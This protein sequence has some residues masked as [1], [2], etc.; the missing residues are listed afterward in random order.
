MSTAEFGDHDL[1]QAP[2]SAPEVPL[3]P[4]TLSPVPVSEMRDVPLGTLILRE[5]LLTEER[6]DEAVQDGIRRGK[7]LGE[8]LVERRLV[9]ENDLGRLL[10]GQKG[11]P[12]VELDAAV[13]D[14]AAVQLLPVERARR[15][16]IL[17]IGFRDGLP[18][19]AVADPTNSLVLEHMRRSLN[20]DPHLVVAARDALQREIE[21]AYGAVPNV[22]PEPGP[23]A[24]PAV[25]AA[26]EAESEAP[27]TPQETLVPP[28][29]EPV[30]PVLAEPRTSGVAADPETAVPPEA[31]EAPETPPVRK[32]EP[33]LAVEPLQQLAAPAAAAEPQAAVQPEPAPSEPLSVSP[34]PLDTAATEQP[35]ADV[36]DRP[37]AVADEPAS[38]A[39]TEA[40]PAAEEPEPSPEEQPVSTWYVVLR[41]ADGERLDIGAFD[42]SADAK[43]HAENVVERISSD[44]GWPFFD[45][46]FL[47]PEAIVS[48]DLVEPEGRWLGSAARRAWASQD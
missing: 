26:T 31:A 25:A 28:A 30:E 40:L 35:P 17:P 46:R 22:Q 5:G 47:R 9:S 29:I 23:V 33:V 43:D 13:I 20:C 14:P 4:P 2:A 19:V 6:L 38:T 3:A 37:V 7:R 16:N 24:P 15:Y 27:L 42:S 18:V 21:S 11:L 34:T 44:S 32:P 45:G 39:V 10:A 8:V 12:F 48:V 41:L 1:G 36:A